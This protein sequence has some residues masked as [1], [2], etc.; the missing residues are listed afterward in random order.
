[1]RCARTHSLRP[2]PQPH[3]AHLQTCAAY[4]SAIASQ[5]QQRPHRRTT[6]VSVPHIS[7]RFIHGTINGDG[8]SA[9][10]GIGT[11]RAAYASHYTQSHTD[12]CSSPST[13]VPFRVSAQS[14]KGDACRTLSYERA[15]RRRASR[16]CAPSCRLVGRLPSIKPTPSHLMAKAML[17]RAVDEAIKAHGAKLCTGA[18]VALPLLLGRP[19][20]LTAAD[21]SVAQPSS[22]CSQRRSH[23]A[24]ARPAQGCRRRQMGGCGCRSGLGFV[25][26][27]LGKKG[28][29]GVQP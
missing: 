21:C 2:L 1:M 11:G 19:L 20:L 25:V 7:V 8:Q 29:R 15:V 5:Q 3:L 6:R 13:L 18:V 17:C 16:F 27:L 26:L 23:S 10:A 28:R 9:V 12:M 14:S 22:L 4:A 24:A